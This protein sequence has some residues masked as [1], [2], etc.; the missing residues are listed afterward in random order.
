[1]KTSALQYENFKIL[2]LRGSVVFERNIC[3]IL[4]I[5]NPAPQSHQLDQLLRI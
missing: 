1:M 4:F 3:L 2:R 5:F